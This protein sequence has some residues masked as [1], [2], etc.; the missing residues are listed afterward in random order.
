MALNLSQ[1]QE[2]VAELAEVAAKAH[3]LVAAEYAGTTVAQMTA[4]RKK[5]RESGV[6]LRVV[7]NTLASR[8]VAGTEFE[9][10]KDALVGPLLYAF[11]TEEPGAAGRLIKEFAKDNDKLKAKLVSVEG[12]LL[13]AAHV[14]VLASLPTREQALAMLARVLAEPA[15]MFARVVKAVADKQGGGEVAAEAPAEA[16]P[17]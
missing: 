5:A 3:S 9:V 10:V 12:K 2:V 8:A 14:D 17:A 11:S 6:Y 7:K 4:M 15:T 13:P 1:K 16:E